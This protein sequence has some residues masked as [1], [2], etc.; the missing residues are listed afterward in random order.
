MALDYSCLTNKAPRQNPS[1]QT[2]QARVAHEL[3]VDTRAPAKSEISSVWATH[4]LSL[5]ILEPVHTEM[6][7]RIRY[8]NL[9][10]ITPQTQLTV[11]SDDDK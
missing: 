2:S 10:R 9:K 6:L 7:H 11:I 4:G 1:V 8:I 5:R 3:P